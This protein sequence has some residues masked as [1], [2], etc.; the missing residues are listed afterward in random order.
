MDT[1]YTRQR[2]PL[3]QVKMS[4]GEPGPEIFSMAAR[5]TGDKFPLWLHPRDLW[6][7]TSREH[8]YYF[9]TDKDAALKENVR[10][11]ARSPW[12]SSSLS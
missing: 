1:E 11:W 6:T 10:V 8:T 7:K 12:R 2:T 9:G 3:A 4:R 5:K